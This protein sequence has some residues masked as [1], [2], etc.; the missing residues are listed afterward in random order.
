MNRRDLLA[1][2]AL[3]SLETRAQTRTAPEAESL[4]I[5]KPQLSGQL[6]ESK[7]KSLNGSLDSHD[8]L[9]SCQVSSGSFHLHLN[10]RT[11][12]PASTRERRA[13]TT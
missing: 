10:T 2:L 7:G 5:P 13:D 4:Y 8:M 9:I 6:Q 11:T 1:G 3:A 12:K